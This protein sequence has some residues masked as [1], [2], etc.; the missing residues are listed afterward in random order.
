MKKNRF[1]W[2]KRTDGTLLGKVK[3]VICKSQKGFEW[4]FKSCAKQKSETVKS[5]AAKP[6]LNTVMMAIYD[7]KGD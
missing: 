3:T 7:R 1:K 6:F 2:L 4:Q 5:K